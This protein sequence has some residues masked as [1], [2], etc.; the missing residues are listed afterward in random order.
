MESPEGKLEVKDYFK[1][2][3]IGKESFERILNDYYR[4][5]GW[6]IV[7]GMPT[8]EKLGQLNLNDFYN[9]MNKDR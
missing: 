6:D 3:V 8:K 7:T 2:V 9:K 4:E 1:S 5:R